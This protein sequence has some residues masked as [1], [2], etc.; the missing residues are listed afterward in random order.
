[1]FKNSIVSRKDDQGLPSV[2]VIV[3]NHNGREHLHPC[4]AS[5]SSLDYPQERLELILVDNGSTDGSIGDMKANFPSVR[6]VRNEHN[7]GFARGNNIG[8][9]EARGQYVAFLN[10]DMRVDPNWLIELVKPV[11]KQQDVVCTASKVLSWDGKKIDFVGGALN[12]Y[13][14]G[15]QLDYGKSNINDYTQERPLLF[16][17]GGAMLI[18]NGVFL[19]CGGFDEDY[20]AFFEDVDLG[21]RLWIQG[22]KVL[23]APKAIVY[24]K[25]HG[26]AKK[27][28][29]HKLRLL[30]ERNALYTIIK[31]YEQQYLDR[32]LPAALLLVVKRALVY[33]DLEYRSYQIDVEGTSQ[34]HENIS[35]LAVSHLVALDEVIHNIPKL[36]E[37]RMK[38]QRSRKRSD[39]EIFGLFEKPFQLSCP[40]IIYAESQSKL[41][42]H[43]HI[44]DIFAEVNTFH[45]L[46]I[47]HDHVGKDMVDPIIRYWEI[48]NALGKKYEV[49]FATPGNSNLASPNVKIK[50]YGSSDDIADLATDADVIL[51]SGYLLYE[52]PLLKEVSKP[53]IVD[54]YDPFTLENLEIHPPRPLTERVTIHKRDLGVL[55]DQ[56]TV[57]DFFICASERHRDFWLGMLHALNRINPY[58][59][60]DDKALRK[61]IDVVPF[62]IPSEPP[63]HTKQVLK[64]IYKTIREGDKV[65][66]WGGG[67]WDWFDPLTLIKAMARIAEKRGDVK[68]FFMGVKRPNPSIPQIKATTQAIQL[69]KKLGLH[70]K[71]VFFNDWV[72]YE[73]RQNYLLEADIGM[74]LHLDHIETRLSFRTRIL[75]YIWAGLP[76]I[77]TK[78]DSISELVERYNLGRVVDYED[79]GQVTDTL[80]ELLGTSNLREV[81]RP[82]FEEVKSHFT[83][84]RAV[85]PLADFCANPHFAPDKVRQMESIAPV[86]PTPWCDLPGKAW[87]IL[88]DQGV[89]ALWAEM[90]RYIR[91]RLTI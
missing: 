49:T 30:Y 12:F 85:E 43:L 34:S 22:Y 17:C 35:K 64:G 66:L 41:S 25:H 27:I 4:F 51:V 24:H 56:L 32:I 87:Q 50:G 47:N 21:W 16:A 13:G 28:A 76:I 48:A 57:G 33:G 6:I 9:A 65:I 69:S 7:L 62:G 5:L 71:F 83:W 74:S 78:G 45:I 1:M 23:F 84:E 91:W 70:D 86:K 54:L 2:S 68:L 75:D 81:Y 72:P 60:D 73:D 63:R 38:V 58:T 82:G 39:S 67:I 88:N 14:H 59:R 46:I 11:L 40:G 26:T 80:M 61:L 19:Q 90:K 42:R 36:M 15:F 18:D 10:N 53:L 44:V 37:K 3:L 8:A 31:N 89:T 29:L 20:F 52:F 79:V 77:T 55:N